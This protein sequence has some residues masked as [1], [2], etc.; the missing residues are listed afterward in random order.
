[1]RRDGGVRRLF[2]PKVGLQ[3]WLGT[4]EGD[5][6]GP[7]VLQPE[8]RGVEP[9]LS[10]IHSQAVAMRHSTAVRLQQLHWG[11]TAQ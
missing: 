8:H 3:L 2:S 9:R 7:S 6:S 4:A 11:N 1:M 5:R 10:R